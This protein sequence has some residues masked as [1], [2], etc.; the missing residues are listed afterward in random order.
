MQQPPLTIF[1]ISG[2]PLTLTLTLPCSGFG[3]T[4]AIKGCNTMTLI[5]CPLVGQNLLTQ[6]R[7]DLDLT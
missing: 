3:R 5:A 4:L 7:G 6:D 2:V 1:R